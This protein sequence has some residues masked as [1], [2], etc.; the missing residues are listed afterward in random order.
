LTEDQGLDVF[1][2]NKDGRWQIVN[3]VAYPER[4]DADRNKVSGVDVNLKP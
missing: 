3:Y 1:E 2:K 4:V